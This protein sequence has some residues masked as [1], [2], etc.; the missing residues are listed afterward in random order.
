M[1]EH[2]EETEETTD[3]LITRVL[4]TQGSVPITALNRIAILKSLAKVYQSELMI[5]MFQNT[6]VKYALCAVHCI[7]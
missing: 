6:L 4:I 1:E 5:L 2:K 7:L 3:T